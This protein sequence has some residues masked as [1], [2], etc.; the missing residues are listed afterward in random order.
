MDEAKLKEIRD[1]LRMLAARIRAADA[2]TSVERAPVE[3]DQQAVGRLSRM[4]AIQVQAMALET[5][6]RRATELRRITA[7]LA[8]IDE[9]EFGYCLECGDEIAARRIEFDPAAPLC[10]GCASGK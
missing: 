9:G 3:L 10:V 8:R 5:S 1:T 7:A 4:D 6:R 2:E